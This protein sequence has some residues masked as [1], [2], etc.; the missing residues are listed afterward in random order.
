MIGSNMIAALLA[1]PSESLVI[2]PPAGFTSFGV[3]GG[4]FTVASQTYTLKN[5]G[6]TPLNWT[7]INTSRW[8]TVSANAGTLNPGQ[9]SSALTISLN[10]AASNFLI[11]NYSGNVSIVNLADGTAQN[12]QFDFY[13]GNGGFETGDFTDWVFVG[14]T[15]YMFTLSGDDVDVAG[16][17]ALYGAPDELF[18][19][20]G[21][22]GAY[23][24]EYPDVGSLSQTVAT[25]PGQHYTVSFWLTCVPYQGSTAPNTFAANWNGSALY[26]VTNVPAFGWTNLQYV[27]PATSSSS[28]LEFELNQV[29][30]AFGLDD[31]SVE[32]LPG[33]VLQSASMTG[34]AI[35][36]SWIGSAG[37][38][39][40]IQSASDLLD[41]TWT[42]V[43]TTVSV[44]GNLVSATEPVGAASQ[45]YYRVI[46]LPSP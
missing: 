16:T 46:Q 13:V 33:P 44:S 25:T 40:Q 35:T 29:P 6:S 8:L 11:G 42:N 23:L 9:D 18:V 4:P 5:I 20:S 30:G 36:F 38:S 26:A 45:K 21:L 19:H 14:N 15:N 32:P 27:V 3:G 39:Y 31:V 34:G 41:S 37:L 28:T 43:P 22:Y 1:P 2:T 12:R 10:S 7:L 24:G 17:N